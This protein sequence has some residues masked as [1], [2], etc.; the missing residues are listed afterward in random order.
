[1]PY[2]ISE[3]NRNQHEVR[4]L[5]KINYDYDYPDDLDLRPGSDLHERIKNEVYARAEESHLVVSNRFD[6]WNSIDQVLTS[7]IDL[8]EEEKTVQE[9][10]QRKPTSIIYPYSYAIMDTLLAYVMK[11]FLSSPIFRY[12]GS[13]PEDTVGAILLEKLIQKQVLKTKVSLNLQTFFRDCFAY[14]IGYAAPDWDVRYGTKRIMRTGGRLST[15]GRLIGRIPE[16]EEEQGILFEGNSLNNINPYLALP[17]PGVSSSNIQSG[18]FFGW[19]EE[20]SLISILEEEQSNQD[21]FNA[22]YLKHIINGKTAISEDNSD[23]EINTTRDGELSESVKDHRDVIHMYMKIIPSDWGL[24]DSEYPEKWLFSVGSDAVVLRAKPL[25][26]N[27]NLFPVAAGSPDF[28]GYSPLPIGRMETLYGLQHTANWLVNSHI[29]NVRKAINDMFVVDPQMVNMNDLKSPEPGKLIRLR[30]AA[31]GRGVRDAVMQLGVSDV[32]R[33]NLGDLSIMI[34]AMNHVAGVDESMMG[35]LRTGGPE[36]LTANEFQGTRSGAVSRLERMA[37]TIGVQALQD[38][39]YMFASHAQQLMSEETYV[40]IT[41]RWEE[42]LRKEYGISDSDSDKMKVSP[43]DID[44][45]YDIDVKDGS[46]PGNNF[47]QSWVDLFQIIGQSESLQQ[48]FDSVQIFQHIAR[49][50]GAQNVEDFKRKKNQGQGQPAQP[51]FMPDEQIREQAAAG[52]IVPRGE[53]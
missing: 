20:T 22:K 28:D 44:I 2:I 9:K 50:L 30:R 4:E 53:T 17:D 40:D 8:D 27:H 25:N 16:T 43:Q 5:S 41:G 18:D 24:G 33:Q 46:L 11:V 21:Y 36:R 7:Y 42:T 12:V 39:G 35:S 34:N 10:D 1:M 31:W 19:I 49:N 15:L 47:S 26:L 45:D 3:P 14:G 13:S 32:T 51:R 37:Q 23:R 29:T 48:E 38:I 6:S 52:N